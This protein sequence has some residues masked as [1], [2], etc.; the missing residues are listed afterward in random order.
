[1]R[2]LLAV[3]I[4]STPRVAVAPTRR[5]FGQVDVQP[6]APL[7]APE[8]DVGFV[9]SLD[10][11]AG[12]RTARLN[13]H[14]PLWFEDLPLV[15]ALHT[16]AS[17]TP[18]DLGGGVYQWQTTPAA[19]T[20]DYASATLV[21]QT[22]GS[23]AL[24]MVGCCA[25]TLTLSG[26]ANANQPVRLDHS[27]LG[28]F[29]TVVAVPTVPDGSRTGALAALARCYL[30]VIW[31]GTTPV[32]GTLQQFQVQ[33]QYPVRTVRLGDGQADWHDVERGDRR[34]AARLIARFNAAALAEIAAWQTVQHRSLRL[35]IVNAPGGTSGGYG[36]E[37]YGQTP[38][39]GSYATS[40]ARLWV[41]LAGDWQAVELG[42]AGATSVVA[43]TLLA[44]GRDDLSGADTRWSVTT[45][46]GSLAAA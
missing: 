34:C 13:L 31:F 44:H 35:E 24:Q 12:D 11:Y 41:D 45:T 8:Y 23:V 43:L 7:T 18:T 14:A 37:P 28:R 10:S 19:Q 38:Y 26:T 39:G 46:T 5:L 22:R 27:Y 32:P 15:L 3:G 36:L 9:P 33:W 25:E 6:L 42:R 20:P 16:R 17:L 4:E 40:T 1:M 30:D 2:E 21:W 29:P